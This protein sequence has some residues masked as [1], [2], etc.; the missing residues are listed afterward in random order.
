MKAT[1]NLFTSSI[2]IDGITIATARKTPNGWYWF[3]NIG[4]VG[5]KNDFP[6]KEAALHAT[7]KTM[8]IKINEVIQENDNDD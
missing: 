2:E 6:S 5:K 3:S 1:L 8:G 7:A 4:R